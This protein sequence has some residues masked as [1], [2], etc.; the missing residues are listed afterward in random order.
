[1]TLECSIIVMFSMILGGLHQGEMLI[2]VLGW[3]CVN[4]AV[5]SVICPPP[6][7]LL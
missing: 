6:Q 7:P 5:E 2:S 1:M 3:L 4:Q